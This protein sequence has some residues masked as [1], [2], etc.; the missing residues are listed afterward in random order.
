MKPRRHP[1]SMTPAARFK[2]TEYERRV[3]MASNR[4]PGSPAQASN[5]IKK[6]VA[7]PKVSSFQYWG[8]TRTFSEHAS[9]KRLDA[10]KNT[11]KTCHGP[12]QNLQK[13]SLGTLPSTPEPQSTTWTASEAK[14][15]AGH[16]KPKPKKHPKMT[17][18]FIK[19]HFQ[20]QACLTYSF[21]MNFRLISTTKKPLKTYPW[22]S[23]NHLRRDDRLR[24]LFVQQ[25]HPE[26]ELEL[27]IAR[28]RKHWFLLLFTVVL[29][30]SPSAHKR[31]NVHPKPVEACCFSSQKR[32][33][34]L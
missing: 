20:T 21:P 6:V 2:A 4:I 17:S 9:T 30:T 24:R 34:K 22:E 3:M 8:P 16:P 5:T 25:T 19:N 10:C 18:K 15:L 26:N 11:P 12:T 1:W 27:V 32:P 28:H 7:P 23:K 29:K 14:V 33:E 13:S 31:Q